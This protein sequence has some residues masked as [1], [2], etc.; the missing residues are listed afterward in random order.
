M[1]NNRY[2]TAK[3]IGVMFVGGVVLGAVAGLLFAP[4]SGRETRREI[5]DAATKVKE[6]VT[7]AA[8]RTKAGI[9]AAV[10]KGRAML[11]ETKAA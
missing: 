3:M 5:K 11:A 8:K 10:E 4:K 6:E 9:E 2:A 7:N 1:E